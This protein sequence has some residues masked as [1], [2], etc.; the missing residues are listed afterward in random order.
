MKRLKFQLQLLIPRL[1]AL[2]KK[3]R[4]IV[5]ANIKLITKF[6]FLLPY[7]LI[8][9]RTLRKYDFSYTLLDKLPDGWRNSFGTELCTKLVETLLSIRSDSIYD[10][11]IIS[12]RLHD[13]S[14]QI[15]DSLP[16]YMSKSQL[17]SLK[18]YYEDKSKL[19]CKYCGKYTTHLVYIDGYSLYVCK[20]KFKKLLAEE[21]ELIYYELTWSHIPLRIIRMSNDTIVRVESELK[22]E[23]MCKWKRYSKFNN[24]VNA[25]K[26]EDNEKTAISPVKVKELW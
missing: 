22:G 2:F 6:P 8:K 13:G 11:K 14:L 20:E 1:R 5:K 9:S 25:T 17:V 3:N 12:F 18:N 7:D 24:S 21:P 26:I 10:Y 23:M 16:Q 4:E 19:I 15:I